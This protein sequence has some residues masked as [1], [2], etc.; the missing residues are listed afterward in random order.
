MGT[1]R[2]VGSVLPMAFC[3]ADPQLCCGP[4]MQAEGRMFDIL[5]LLFLLLKLYLL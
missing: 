1:F 4:R 5:L 2:A 3:F